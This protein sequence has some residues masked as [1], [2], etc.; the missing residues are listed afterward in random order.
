[1]AILPRTRSGSAAARGLPSKR[2][3]IVSQVSGY[4]A[5]ITVRNVPAGVTQLYLHSPIGFRGLIPVLPGSD[6]TFA[7]ERD[8]PAAD[9]LPA[10]V[11]SLAVP[12]YKSNP[13][14]L[15]FQRETTT[16]PPPIPV[17]LGTAA[18]VSTDGI[19]GSTFTVTAA[20]W[21]GD[22]NATEQRAEIAA[23]LGG[24]YS[25]LG[26]GSVPATIPNSVGQFI[27][28]RSGA[29]GPTA[30]NPDVEGWVYNYTTPIEIKA[31]P[32]A[33]TLV[34]GVDFNVKRSVY[35][36]NTGQQVDFT[37]ILDFPGLSGE[38]APQIRYT[39]ADLSTVN[40]TYGNVVRIG[41]TSEY[42]LFDANHPVAS[43][44][45]DGA[46][47]QRNSARLNRLRFSWRPS[48]DV[49]WSPN[50]GVVT[51]PQ[52]VVIPTDPLTTIFAPVQAR[53]AESV[54]AGYQD[55]AVMLNS[56]NSVGDGEGNP[57]GN[58]WYKAQTFHPLL[59]LYCDPVN[60][61]WSMAAAGGRGTKAILEH[62][63]D[64]LI[65]WAADDGVNAPICRGGYHCQHE[66]KFVTSV[67]LARLVPTVWNH[68]RLLAKYK[69]RLSLMMEACLVAYCATT[70]DYSPFDPGFGPGKQRTIRGFTAD[71]RSNPNF[72]SPALLAPYVIAAFMEKEG[73]N[74]VTWMN[75][76]TRADFHAALVAAWPS[77]TTPEVIDTFA[78]DW[79][80]AFQQARYTTAV[81][82]VGRGFTADEIKK[83]LNNDGSPPYKAFGRGLADYRAAFV[84]ELAE[85]TFAHPVSPGLPNKRWPNSAS[86][87]AVGEAGPAG[88]GWEDTLQGIKYG[89]QTENQLRGCL[90]LAGANN[91]TTKDK[92]KDLPNPG[93]LG[94]HFEFD[95][96]N[97]P[98][99]NYR[100]SASY[101]MGGMQATMQLFI[102]MILY[103]KFAAG[104][105]VWTDVRSRF[106]VGIRDFN[107]RA[108][109]GHRSYAN[110]GPGVGGSG[111][112]DFG[113]SWLS[114]NAANWPAFMDMMN[115]VA[116]WWGLG[117]FPT[118]D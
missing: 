90:G 106:Q 12:G 33:R 100:S 68:A 5:Q 28:I 31:V 111:S 51:V 112:E 48:S 77:G 86:G 56:A 38:S 79:T 81:K 70:S 105:A 95:T 46:L 103:G 113:P 96:T 117:N 64:Q 17:T 75:D 44:A 53:V 94:M 19:V 84:R 61:N 45:V 30:A 13:H 15:N 115:M 11:I 67:A 8:E 49:P 24:P 108:K 76:W 47:F 69:T 7:F 37:P 98:T 2:L 10:I 72:S 21:L 1:M 92:W 63:V 91:V 58:S 80:V 107:F 93:A 26:D 22:V 23:S 104:D 109:Y 59:A 82:S 89:S 102:C 74:P 41:S 88:S 42:E 55:Y 62:V 118:T 34:A 18:T 114:S 110:G 85:R 99:P 83:A 14:T 78:Q 87:A 3:K 35:R 32:A 66:Q 6:H 54:N 101:A 20:S 25:I 43:G 71:R 97:G 52:P 40:P 4:N 39:A 9:E 57:K 116:R 16:P 60:N 73:K 36:P 29:L 27:R 50:S 65:R